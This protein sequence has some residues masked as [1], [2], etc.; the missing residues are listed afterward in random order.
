MFTEF[1]PDLAARLRA[2]RTPSV[3]RRLLGLRPATGTIRFPVGLLFELGLGTSLVSV[4]SARLASSTADWNIEQL[5]GSVVSAC[6]A[7][8]RRRSLAIALTRSNAESAVNL[9]WIGPLVAF[10]NSFGLAV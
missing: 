2:T 6:E 7:G 9:P 4:V 10:G 3:G 8:R 1:A 5:A